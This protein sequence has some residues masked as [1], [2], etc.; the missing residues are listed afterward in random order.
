RMDVLK[1]LID[2]IVLEY[3]QTVEQRLRGGNAAALLDLGQGEI[4]VFL[5]FD[6]AGMQTVEPFAGGKASRHFDADRNRTNQQADDVLGM[7]YRAV[8]P[9]HRLSQHDRI[10]AA[11]AAQQIGPA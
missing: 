8:A 2:R 10:A 1:N 5:P 4:A 9:R 7:P 11:V 3:D 6:G